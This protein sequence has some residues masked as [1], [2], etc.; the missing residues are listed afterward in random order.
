MITTAWETLVEWAAAA[1]GIGIGIFIYLIKI[2][3]NLLVENWNRKQNYADNRLN[4]L[5]ADMKSIK[6]V[7]YFKNPKSGEDTDLF[8]YVAHKFGNQQ[9]MLNDIDRQVDKLDG[10]HND[11]M[12]ILKQIENK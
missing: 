1:I 4:L 2:I 11:L 8:V 9:Q 7:L 10:N 12:K 3:W 6:S 5:E